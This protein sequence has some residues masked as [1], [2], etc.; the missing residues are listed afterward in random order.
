[1][2][3]ALTVCLLLLS[4]MGWSGEEKPIRLFAEAEDFQVEQGPWRVVP[5][6]ENY[7]AATF[8]VTFLSRKACLGAPAQCREAV[9]SQ[10]IEVPYDGEFHVAARYEQPYRF[11]VEFTVVIEQGGQE[12]YRETFGRLDDPK[13]WAFN[14][15]ER[16]PMH[17]YGW[18]GTDNIVWQLKG[19]A[20][21]AAGA[22]TLRLLAGPQLEGEEPR[23]MA[24]ERHVD[25]L[26]LTNDAAGLAAQREKARYLELDGWLVQDG[27]LF[28]RFTNPPDGLGPCLPVVAPFK[29]GQH[30]PY[31][32]HVR[33][34]PTT[35]VLKTGRVVSPTDYVNAGP[36]SRQV[37]T[38]LLAP[39][40]QRDA[41]AEDDY[42]QPGDT[43]PWVPLGQA[44]DALNNSIWYPRA[45]YKDATGKAIDLICQFAIPDGQGALKP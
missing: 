5:W 41:I 1:M 44:I 39:V 21:L 35:R 14:D 38:P 45:Q 24:A 37:A 4:A 10:P 23:A 2:R 32:V 3:S 19:T 40:V 11:A 36:R 9:A 8:A 16:V 15:H 12:V 27:D 30:S 7:Y 33:D 42:L 6:G 20:P 34:W 43:S 18:G 26:C 13:I 22:A 31:W 25:L 28:V 29:Q 17:R